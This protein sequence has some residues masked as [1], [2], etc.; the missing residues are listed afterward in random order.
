MS[1]IPPPEANI[2][3]FA[4]NVASSVT[5]GPTNSVSQAQPTNVYI[6]NIFGNDAH[7][8]PVSFA[9]RPMTEAQ[10]ALV[11]EKGK[12]SRICRRIN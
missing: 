9:G 8:Q 11:I 6:P 4:A 2:P 1:N 3:V 10:K 7:A 12:S 5:F